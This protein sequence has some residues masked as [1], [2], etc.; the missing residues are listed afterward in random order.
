MAMNTDDEWALTGADWKHGPIYTRIPEN[1]RTVRSVLNSVWSKYNNINPEM[2]AEKYRQR[3]YEECAVTLTDWLDDDGS[4]VK[5]IMKFSK[6]CT[7]LMLNKFGGY[8]KKSEQYLNAT[9]EQALK[10]IQENNK[11]LW[12]ADN[13][14]AKPLNRGG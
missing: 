1:V 12:A 7:N 10:I 5:N 13:N 8:F 11:S 14:Y 4:N 6:E 2:L 3:L 9:K